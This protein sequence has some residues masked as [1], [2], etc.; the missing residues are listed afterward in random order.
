[1][2]F[3]LPSGKEAGLKTASC[4]VTRA[5]VPG[6]SKPVIRPYTP[7]SPADAVGYLELVVKSYE[8]GKM[9]KHICNL[10]VGDTLDMKGPIPKLPYKAN[11]VKRIGMVCGGTGITPMLQVIDAVVADPADST[12]V[13]LIYANMTEDDIILKSKIDKIVKDHKNIKV[14][15]VVDKVN[16]PGWFGNPYTVGRVSRALLDKTMP[17]AS[18]ECLMLVCGPP[19]MMEAV[20]GKKA[21]DFSQGE[22]SGLFKDMGFSSAQVFKF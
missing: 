2:K 21:P 20:S 13:H 11:M 5:M 4:L 6:E 10:Q 18:D 12:E 17:A 19:G 8:A 14:T 7:T 22:V 15:Y 3:E 1:L 9:S 16:K